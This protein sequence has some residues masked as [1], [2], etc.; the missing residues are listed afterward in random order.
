MM[1]H[2]IR[3]NLNENI[4]R[5]DQTWLSATQKINRPSD[6]PAGIVNTL[7]YTSTIIESST[8]RNLRPG[9][10]LNSTDSALDNVTDICIGPRSDAS[11]H[12]WHSSEAARE[13]I[14]AEIN[15]QTRSG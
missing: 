8:C 12:Q 3:Y 5:Q 2:N 4:R 15:S 13:A 9:N 7:R 11:G 1:T 6:N 10:F 14:A